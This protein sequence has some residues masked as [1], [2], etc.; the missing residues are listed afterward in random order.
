MAVEKEIKINVNTKEAEK[1]VDNLEGSIDGVAG[2]IDKMTGGMVSGF[3]NGVKGIK[4]GVKA[5]KSLK[6]RSAFGMIT[7]GSFGTT[8]TYATLTV[9]VGTVGMGNMSLASPN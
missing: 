8:T 6:A 5:M 7:A 1:N 9:F 3:R 2:R 4:Q